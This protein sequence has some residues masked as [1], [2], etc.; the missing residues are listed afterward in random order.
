MRQPRPLHNAGLRC[1]R[2]AL[3]LLI[4]LAAGQVFGQAFAPYKARGQF[5]LASPGGLGSG[6]HGYVNPA[7]LTYVEQATST[8][9]WSDAPEKGN[10]WGSFSA[11]PHLGFG[12]VHWGRTDDVTDYELAFSGGNRSYSFGLG[13]GWSGG[14][15]D[16]AGR[17]N[18][19]TGGLLFR[20]S[21]YLSLGLTQT[22]ALSSSAR[23]LAGDLA[24]RPTGSERI[25][26][27]TDFALGNAKAGD[28]DSWSVGGSFQLTS[29]LH[30]T[31]RY[32]DNRSI[33]IGLDLALD[34]LGLQSQG[35]FDEDRNRTFNTYAV[36]LGGYEHNPAV[37][38]FKPPGFLDLQM[39]RPVRHRKYVL[40]D[41]STSLVELLDLI[42]R[43]EED[44]RIAGIAINT[45]G[46]RINPAMA[47][48]LRTR[49]E[50]F[51]QSGKPVVMYLDEAGLRRYHFATV[52]D[53]IVLDPAGLVTLEG[54]V[55]GR[56]YLKGSMEK[57]GIGVDEWRYFKYKSAAEFLSREEMSAA[58]RE[59]RAALLDDF[60]GLARSEI[61]AARGISEAGFDRLVD[62]EALFLPSTALE[63]GLVDQLGRWDDVEAILKELAGGEP[64]MIPPGKFTRPLDRSWGEPPSIAVIY[65]LGVCAMDEGINARQLVEEIDA[66]AKVKGIRAVVLRVDSPGG[67]LLPSDLVADALKKLGEEKPVIVSQGYV[68]ASG[69]YW[70][71]MYGDEIVAAPN[72][73]TGSVG[74]IGG[75][76]YDQGL[77]E[78]LGASTDH[79]QVGAHADLGFGMTIPLLGARLP[80]R[81][82][83]SDER[84]IMERTIRSMYRQFVDKV[85]EGRGKTAGEIEA[86]AQGRVW[87]G[88]AALENGL[89]D[90]LGGLDTAIQLA[91]EEAGL[92][93]DG[94]VQLEEY[95]K[96]N[97]LSPDFWRNRMT[98]RVPPGLPHRSP[99]LT[100]ILFR[101]EHNGQ[102][103]LILP[104]DMMGEVTPEMD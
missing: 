25:T 20:P 67:G 102:P 38:R 87:S 75:W 7:L 24:V 36:R 18:R 90:R 93:P 9:A 40:F 74:V 51:K 91:V 94:R 6:L 103:L 41:P 39:N 4:C 72:T 77:K 80:D 76:L 53:R 14:P 54:F 98:A 82:L 81:P 89:V 23:E 8:F 45:S 31:G 97:L 58:D 65:A 50:A 34:H 101:L 33:N 73:I 71:S 96:Q 21:A 62:E 30:L 86:I 70:L 56:T 11:F 57:M 104:L 79:V 99:E 27:F 37:Q 61:C 52:A 78:K 29:G 100:Q 88:K 66:I 63:R 12:M 59:Q 49:L 43:A 46:L 55:S 69:G 10:E 3:P 15:T 84:D 68:A 32:F 2:F 44:P 64:K 5:L 22:S 1:R 28:V 85:S 17:K 83:T 95:P 48:E 19:F 47:W 35:R 92:D 42:D 26:F 16:R 60:Y 13:Y